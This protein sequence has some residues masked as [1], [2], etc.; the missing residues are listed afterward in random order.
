[1]WA[2]GLVSVAALA[3]TARFLAAQAVTAPPDP[4][5]EQFVKPFLQQN[6]VKCHNVENSTAAF[7]SIS[8]IRGLTMPR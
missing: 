1:M 3:F 2:L 8:S 4:L 5:F 7:A 6:C